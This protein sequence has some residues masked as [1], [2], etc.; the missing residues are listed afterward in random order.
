MN[1]IIMIAFANMKK[2]KGALFT[3]LLIIIVAA[4]LLNLGLLTSFNYSKSFE[5]RA[6]ELHSAH[7]AIAIPKSAE[8]GQ[9]ETYFETYPGVEEMEKKDVLFFQSAQFQYR[10]GQLTSSV[11]ILNADIQYK[12]SPLTF[13]GEP[14]KNGDQDIYV[15]YLLHTGGGYELGDL[16]VLKYNDVQYTFRIAGFTEDILLGSPNIGCIDFHLS[17]AA[18]RKFQKELNNEEAKGVLLLARLKNLN[19]S[20]PMTNDISKVDLIQ[21]YWGCS[22]TAAKN[23]RTLTANIGALI[24]TIFSLMIF[25]V[26]LLVIR[27]RVSTSIEDDMT[28]IGT[29]KALGYTSTQVIGSVLL[30]FILISVV[31]S[32]LGILGS[33]AG[34]GM[35]SEMFSAQTGILWK[36]GFDIV[37]SGIS[38]SFILLSVLMFTLL[39]ALRIKKLHPII[40]LRTGIMTHSFKRNHFPL[41]QTRGRLNY[42]LAM[43]NMLTNIKQ[44]VMI[45][46]IIITVSFSSVFGIIMYYNIVQND[47]AFINMVGDETTSVIVD[48]NAEEES[49]LQLDDILKLEGVEKAIYYDN[50]GGRI[51]EEFIIIHVTD[52]FALLENNLVYE[53]RYPK[54]DNEIAM[55]AVMAKK[56]GK[57]LGDS[58]SLS[59][60]EGAT[61]YLITGFSQ[62][63]SF[64]GRDV[65]L[66]L[67]GYKRIQ[68][69]YTY[70]S[71]YI[72]LESGK[73]IVLFIENMKNELGNRITRCINYDELMRSQLGVYTLLV[74]VIATAIMIIIALLIVLILFL[75]INAWIIRRRKAFGIQKAIGYTTIQL[76]VQTSLSFQPMILLGSLIGGVLGS[77]Y[78]NELISI[79]FRSIGVM[80]VNFEIPYF[81]IFS[82]SIGICFLSF[83][84]AMLVSW[85][86]RKISAYTLMTE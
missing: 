43:K 18:Y 49:V 8:Q 59:L 14:I 39:S 41:D 4:M 16:F 26:S 57:K 72:Y 81:W 78:M 24:I 38:V 69:E 56:L 70:R 85:R 64:M 27:F 44:N 54:Y 86:I 34:V 61:E 12:I 67:E 1:K 9:Y 74:S 33:Y 45:F 37:T 79:L 21:N 53:G 30:Q 28:Q 58:V 40:A 82:M 15:P 2:S 6:E 65:S 76:M 52:D 83:V 5:Q 32:L 47:K 20:T 60:A 71:I 66:T 46:V 3:L 22:Y 31:G 36:Q 7:V 51:S 19:D 10:E 68:P 77:L 63:G 17:D 11:V 62:S 29:L 35:L 48:I 50:C 80:K 73:D 55:N 25:F 23:V 13:V 75:M 42:L 84:V